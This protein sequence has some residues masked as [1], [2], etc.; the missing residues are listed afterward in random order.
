MTVDAGIAT[1]DVAVAVE[2][3]RRS[4]SGARLPEIDDSSVAGSLPPG[5]RS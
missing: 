2:T 3:W 1:L 5:G 4:R